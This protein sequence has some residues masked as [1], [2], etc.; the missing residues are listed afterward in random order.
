MRNR[1]RT[2]ASAGAFFVVRKFLYF[3]N[4]LLYNKERIIFI[5]YMLVFGIG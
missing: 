1:I 2:P 3:F 4:F 5:F